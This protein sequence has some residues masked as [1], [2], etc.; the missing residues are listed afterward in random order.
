MIDDMLANHSL[1]PV[2][3]LDSVEDACW[4]AKVLLNHNIRIIEVT[5]RTKCALDVVKV[6]KQEFKD[7]LV[8]VGTVV[9]VDDL[10]SVCKAGADFAVSPGF[11]P[12]MVT[13]AQM[14]SLPF[15]PAVSTVSEAMQ[16]LSLGLKLVKVYPVECLGG[17]DYLSSLHA[18]LPDMQFCPTGG[19][20]ES[21]CHAYQSL[22]Y[23]KSIGMSSLASKTHIHR[24]DE[25]GLSQLLQQCQGA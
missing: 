20:N 11:L 4:L 6:L 15:M 3:T 18:V 13:Q 17:V 10:S 5:M 25:K 14:Y 22:C 23:V 24:R 19:I 16:A 1:I 2:A 8:G 9:N 21:N 7:L 12:F